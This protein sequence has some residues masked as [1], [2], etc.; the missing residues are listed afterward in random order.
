[1]VKRTG[2]QIT[3]QHRMSF[4]FLNAPNNLLSS[5]PALNYDIGACQHKAEGTYVCT[6]VC[7]SILGSVELLMLKSFSQALGH[8]IIF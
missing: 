5:T 3:T 1:M 8:Y 6:H 4:R 2:S 7:H